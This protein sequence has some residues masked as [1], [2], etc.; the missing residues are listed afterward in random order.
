MG[1]RRLFP[2]SFQWINTV[3]VHLFIDQRGFVITI[4]KIY[5]PDLSGFYLLINF[6]V[7]ISKFSDL[8][9]VISHFFNLYVSGTVAFVR[10]EV[11]LSFRHTASTPLCSRGK[12][13]MEDRDKSQWSGRNSSLP[14]QNFDG[15]NQQASETCRPLCWLL[16]VFIH[17]SNHQNL[18]GIMD[19][20]SEVS[21]VSTIKSYFQM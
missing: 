20:F 12:R 1:H 6:I 9:F 7:I 17:S 10:T 4:S 5:D 19:L 14:I 21:N 15:P 11:I 13:D 16:L 3:Q 2:H 8:L 18:R